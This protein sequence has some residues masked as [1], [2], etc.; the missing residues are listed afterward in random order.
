MFEIRTTRT[1][2][3]VADLRD[4]HRAKLLRTVISKSES[5]NQA[6]LERRPVV[7]YASSGVRRSTTPSARKCADCGSKPYGR[8]RAISSGTSPPIVS[9]MYCVPSCM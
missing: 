2:A 5:L 3:L 7:A 6:N 1:N 9:A 8:L 4:D